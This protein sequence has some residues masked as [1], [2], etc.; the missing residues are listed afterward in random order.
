MVSSGCTVSRPIFPI[1]L[2]FYWL[3]GSVK[4]R[5]LKYASAGDQC[6]SS[7]ANS[8]DQNYTKLIVSQPHFDFYSFEISDQNVRKKE[9]DRFLYDLLY[10]LTYDADDGNVKYMA[11]FLFASL[12]H[13]HKYMA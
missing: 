6:V 8:A 9:L 7:C 13:H 1:S 3:M 2:R 4:D 5:Y 11:K 12:L 10:Q